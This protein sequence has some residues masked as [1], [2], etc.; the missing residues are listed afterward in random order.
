MDKLDTESWEDYAFRNNLYKINYFVKDVSV[1]NDIIIPTH[2]KISY[3]YND[4][5]YCIKM[6]DTGF[7]ERPNFLEF[8]MYEL[9]NF[10]TYYKLQTFNDE[11]KVKP[12][13]MSEQVDKDK[14]RQNWLLGQMKF[15]ERE[16]ENAKEEKRILNEQ[17]SEDIKTRFIELKANISETHKEQLEEIFC[18]M[19][20]TNIGFLEGIDKNIR[21]L[22]GIDKNPYGKNFFEEHKKELDEYKKELD[23]RWRLI[24]IKSSEDFAL[25]KKNR[26]ELYQKYQKYLKNKDIQTQITELEQKLT[27]L[28]SEIV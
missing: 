26:I 6:I 20:T 2:P 28:K 13:H 22:E 1:I 27:K 16:N 15:W 10:K 12:E 21:F 11:I 17:K 5:T 25:E 4:A 7:R 23:K 18:I 19:K 24:S 9:Y 3:R 8:I 14:K